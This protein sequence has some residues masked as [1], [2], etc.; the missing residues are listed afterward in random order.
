[1]FRVWLR[2]EQS[3]PVEVSLERIALA[4]QDSHHAHLDGRHVEV[5]IE[6]P[7]P[8]AGWLRIG[9]RVYPFMVTECDGDLCVWLKGRKHKICRVD[10]T[11]RRATTGAAA[12]QQNELTAPMPGR[13][14]K[15]L[16]EPG[17][18]FEAHQPLIV[19]ESMKMEMTISAPHAGRVKSISCVAGALV[20]M[21][22]V[23]ATLDYPDA[24]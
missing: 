22:A 20:E 21:G 4:Q 19:I 7:Q 3:D 9:G 23:L 15:T 17:D 10:R 24:E 12:G 5:E 14:L 6:S 1:M 13:V 18:E 2:H 8:G 16:V 11:P